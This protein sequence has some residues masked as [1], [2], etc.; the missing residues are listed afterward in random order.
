[1]QKV[2]AIDCDEVLANTIDSI[3]KFNGHTFNGLPIQRDDITTFFWHELPK[4]SANPE[5]VKAYRD[6]FFLSPEAMHIVPLP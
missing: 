6:D 3:F 5:Y 2:I 1:M 4:F